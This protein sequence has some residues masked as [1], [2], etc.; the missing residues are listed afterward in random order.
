MTSTI[1]WTYP[2]NQNPPTYTSSYVGYV[3]GDATFTRMKVD[4]T[5]WA[6]KPSI[7]DITLKPAVNVKSFEIWFPAATLG[8]SSF[9]DV[10][11][12]RVYDNKLLPV[13]TSVEGDFIVL[14]FDT[15]VP[16]ARHHELRMSP[17]WIAPT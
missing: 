4:V 10:F 14:R 1:K 7:S 15:P 6:T 3:E 11:A 17:V 2:I 8:L 5:A 9:S 12:R 16:I 13:T